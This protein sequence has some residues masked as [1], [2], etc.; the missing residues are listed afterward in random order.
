VWIGC[1]IG[2]WG[3]KKKTWGYNRDLAIQNRES[4]NIFNMIYL[5]AHVYVYI[6][7][8]SGMAISE[9]R[10][11]STGDISQQRFG[12]VSKCGTNPFPPA[13]PVGFNKDS[14]VWKRLVFPLLR[15]KPFSKRGSPP[16][17]PLHFNQGLPSA[18]APAAL[19]T[20][21][22]AD[23]RPRTKAVMKFTN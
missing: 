7:I 9:A 15:L 4:T 6:Y 11:P 8:P 19:L 2:K 12:F 14:A 17:N 3:I 22:K 1:D 13:I 16:R 21:P 18:P 20:M 23:P 5:H 10:K